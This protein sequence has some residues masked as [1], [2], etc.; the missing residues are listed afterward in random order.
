MTGTVSIVLVPSKYVTMAHVNGKTDCTLW[1]TLT[2]FCYTSWLLR[3]DPP[4]CSML[5][6]AS[7]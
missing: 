2:T 5:C 4:V 1:P 3:S 7:V 6:S